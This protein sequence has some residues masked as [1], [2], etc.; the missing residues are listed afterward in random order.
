MSGVADETQTRIIQIHEAE[1]SLSYE[2]IAAQIGKSAASVSYV[3][4]PYKRA[5]AAG[6]AEVPLKTLRL[7][8]EN[9][10]F[11]AAEARSAGVSLSEMIDAILTDARLDAE[12]VE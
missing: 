9:F 11:L 12:G 8:L 2:A 10:D 7:S 1:P 6:V 3:L 5:R 4:T